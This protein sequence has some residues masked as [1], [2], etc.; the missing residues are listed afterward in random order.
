[1]EIWKREYFNISTFQSFTS[2]LLFSVKICWYFSS[3]FC[4]SF[5]NRYGEIVS[6]NPSN[7]VLYFRQQLFCLFG[8]EERCFDFFGF[9]P[10]NSCFRIWE[11]T[12]VFRHSFMFFSLFYISDSIIDSQKF[13][14]IVGSCTINRRM[15]NLFPCV[16]FYCPV[17][18]RS[19]IS[20]TWGIH[21]ERI[22]DER[23]FYF[24]SMLVN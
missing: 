24:H 3:Y 5:T 21:A 19:W 15:K 13:S 6:F 1:M 23:Y 16:E 10:C 17:F 12:L 22:R 8:I 20:R 7:C 14:E 11:Y 2:F 18:H 9:H 4:F